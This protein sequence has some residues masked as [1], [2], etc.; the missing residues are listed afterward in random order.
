MLRL[1]STQFNLLRCHF[2]KWS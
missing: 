1:N 2:S